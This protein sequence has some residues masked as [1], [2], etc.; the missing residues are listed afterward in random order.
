MR[1][2]TLLATMCFCLAV[3]GCGGCASECSSDQPA[4]RVAGGHHHDAHGH[5]GDDHADDV[6]RGPHGGRL[7]RD[8]DFV[9]EIA[10][11]ERGVP[12]E[13]HVYLSERGVPVPLDDVDLDVELRRLG[14]RR[15]V[16]SFA[17]AAGFLRSRETVE[18]PHSFDVS[19]EA[20]QAGRTHRWRYP[21]YE[22]RIQLG[23]PSVRQA[24][25]EVEA[26]GPAIVRRTLR[27]TGRI[28]PNEDRLAHLIPRFP[29]IVRE[30]YKRLGDSVEKG[31]VLAVVQSNESLE[32][33]ELRSQ[34]SGTVIKKHVTPGEFVSE[35]DDVYVVA[36]LGSVWVDL[37]V[38]RQ[39]FPL[40][41]V[42]Q[43]VVLDAGE[44]IEP[45]EGTIDYIS[46]F[47]APSTQTM[48]ARVEL[49]N[50]EGAWRP[51]LFVTAEVVVDEVEVPVAVRTAALQTLR[52]GPSVFVRI[53]DLFEARP[54]DVG[55]RDATW[56]EVRS[57]L[58]AG[59]RY[60]SAN[61]FVLKAELG[62]AGATHDH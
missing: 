59:D 18:E 37:N 43:T 60:A 55:R 33:Y 61:S 4:A 36:D 15:D 57:G 17:P 14:G 20:T 46:P 50:R 28:Q 35:K 51:G 23:E 24:N 31:E 25:I 47:G 58:E 27:L 21:S 52:I 30:V 5:G 11:Y 9:A 13:M 22:G 8:G 49:P 1:L 19:V 53:G 42:G 39:D 40:L 56:T 45:A 54:I 41:R 38:Y 16:L 3:I 44:G 29:G 10:I 26:A 7:L 32:R 2:S 62:K 6:E 34:I 48:L 12:P